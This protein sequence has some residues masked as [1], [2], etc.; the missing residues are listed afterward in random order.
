MGLTPAQI[1]QAETNG[2]KV[3][4][5]LLTRLSLSTPVLPSTPITEDSASAHFYDFSGTGSSSP[6]FNRSYVSLSSFGSCQVTY[7]GGT[8][9]CVPSAQTL[10][11]PGIDAGTLTVSGAGQSTITL[12]ESPTGN[13]SAGLGSYPLPQKGFPTTPANY[14]QPGA[15]TFAG[16]GSTSG[17]AGAFSASI[18]VP[19]LLNWATNPATAPGATI[20]RT[21]PLAFTWST[22]GTSASDYVLLSASSATNVG[23]ADVTTY[24]SATVLCLQPASAGSYTIP[25]WLL[26]ALPASSTVNVGLPIPSGAILAGIFNVTGTTT[27]PNIDLALANSLVTSGVSVNIQ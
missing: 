19:G 4:S 8:Y 12:T 10:T 13:Y 14:L 16:S 11:I 25:A 18:N 23:T 3:G 27:I 26:Q 7:C 6:D 22:S 5:L 9:T 17:G 24:N 20:N 15:F 1:T 2:L 21:S